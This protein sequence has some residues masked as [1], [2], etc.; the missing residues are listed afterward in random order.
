MSSTDWTSL[1]EAPWIITW[2]QASSDLDKTLAYILQSL[3]Q[4]TGA[5][6]DMKGVG[7]GGERSH[8]HFLKKVWKASSFQAHKPPF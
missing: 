6:V 5:W 8:P 3:Y 7:A 1:W 2:C 4:E